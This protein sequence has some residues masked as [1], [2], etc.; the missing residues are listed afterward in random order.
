M[1]RYTIFFFLSFLLLINTSAQDAP[2]WEILGAINAERQAQG[3][4]PLA[5]N[6]Q[7]VAAAQRHSDDLASNDFLSHVGS[8][9]SEFWQRITEA[10]YPMTTG[11]ENVLFRWDASGVGAFQ[12]WRDSPPHYANMMNP[13]YQEMGA[14]YSLSASGKYYFTLVLASRS[15]F[16]APTNTPV[17]L[18]IPTETSSPTIN[19]QP[20]NTPISIVPTHTAT[21][22]IV[23]TSTFPTILPTVPIPAT[24]TTPPFVSFLQASEVYQRIFRFPQTLPPPLITII[25]PTPTMPP[26]PPTWT[27][28]PVTPTAVLTY[29]LR[30]IY[31]WNSFI[32]KNTSGRP[33]FLEGLSFI[34]A[35]GRF[36][37]ERWDNGYLT[38]PLSAFPADDCLQ[39]WDINTDFIEVPSVCDSRH[40]WATVNNQTTFWR[41]VEY[42]DVY[43]YGERVTTCLIAQGYC[44]FNLT[45]RLPV[46]DFASPTAMV[47]ADNSTQTGQNQNTTPDQV[48]STTD[49]TLIYSSESFAL[50]NT[51]GQN[52]DLTGL[53]FASANGIMNISEWDTEFLTRPL[54]DFPSGDCLQ[55]WSVYLDGQLAKPAQC[56]WRH[57]YLTV[58]EP[59]QFWMNT[60][61]FTVSRGGAVL[62]TCYVNTG[63]CTFDLP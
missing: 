18:V 51:S 31:D 47:A 23:A 33:L 63:I 28:I 34:S 27:P 19:F 6:M 59:R 35:S 61:V 12:Q 13:A 43:R 5:M 38:A 52:L 45:D 3:I 9:G 2:A 42:F 55:V 17:S 24:A 44:D 8:D 37:S 60:D 16:S 50:I 4:Q 15:N 7:L 40:A 32:L 62:A 58:G 26:P 30:L 46:P 49:I 41:N 54:W 56:N 25:P 1:K 29:D 36:D 11:A 14:A 48:D 22:F 20:T 57:A 53:G 10:G 39:I 21:P